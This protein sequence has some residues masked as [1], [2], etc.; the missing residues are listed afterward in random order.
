MINTLLKEKLGMWYSLPWHASSLFPWV[1]TTVLLT[2][3]VKW[4]GKSVSWNESFGAGCIGEMFL[5]DNMYVKM[6]KWLFFHFRANLFQVCMICAKTVK[7]KLQGKLLYCF[8]SVT[9][10]IN[11]LCSFLFIHYFSAPHVLDLSLRFGMSCLKTCS[12]LF[13]W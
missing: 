9:P 7:Y 11:I 6:Q 5:L 10:N 1:C 8:G 4:N 2:Q 13:S 12:V 3:R